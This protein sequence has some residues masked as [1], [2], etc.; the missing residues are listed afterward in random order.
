MRDVHIRDKII[1]DCIILGSPFTVGTYSSRIVSCLHLSRLGDCLTKTKIFQIL[2]HLYIDR[3]DKQKKHLTRYCPFQKIQYL[4]SLSENLK[5][6]LGFLIV[7]AESCLCVLYTAL[8]TFKMW[9]AALCP[10]DQYT[11]H[12]ER[13]RTAQG[14]DTVSL[15]EIFTSSKPECDCAR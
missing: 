3:I 2:Y 9:C 5:E 14:Q 15:Q 7:I 8:G 6:N 11:V 13:H 4:I 1:K 10:Y 12:V